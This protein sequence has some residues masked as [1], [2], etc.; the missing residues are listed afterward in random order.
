MVALVVF[1]DQVIRPFA[2]RQRQA[3]TSTQ[4]PKPNPVDRR[5]EKLRN[6]MRLLFLDLGLVA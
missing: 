1:R 5:Y 4:T 6:I 3:N 2:R